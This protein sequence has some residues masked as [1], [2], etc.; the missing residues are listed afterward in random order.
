MA[1]IDLWNN[2]RQQILDKRIDQLISFA[3]EGKLRDGN[4]T[5]REFRDLLSIVPSNVLGQW[6]MECLSDRHT[7]FG[8]VL[9]D[10]VNE[11]GHRLKFAVV[12]GT[13]RPIAHESFN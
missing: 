12:F 13:Y 11:I 5:S 6:I 7:D 1:L 10:I 3:G 2:D 4:S 9:Q 8:L